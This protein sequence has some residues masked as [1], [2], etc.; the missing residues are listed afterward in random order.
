MLLYIVRHAWA[1]DRDPEKFPNDDLRPLTSDGKKRF[2]KTVKRLVDGGC[3]PAL[4]ATS[5]LVRCRQTADILTERLENG[6]KIV[7]LD[8][9]RP[10][11][12]LAELVRWTSE[13]SEEAIAWVGH[14]PDVS[15]LAAALIG[16][17]I[18]SIRFTKGATAA[19]EFTGKIAPG[20]GELNWLATAKLLGC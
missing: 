9:L 12:D 17:G 4:V 1:E 10:G 2:T 20:K 19:I 13:Q 18:P 8:A 11:S 3:C 7:E 14:A 16:D 15:E 5:P 6:T